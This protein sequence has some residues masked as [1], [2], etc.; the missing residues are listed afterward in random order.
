MVLVF[1]LGAMGVS[2]A[3]G[4]A[5]ATDKEAKYLQEQFL[6]DDFLAVEL[7]DSLWFHMI[8][9]SEGKLPEEYSGL[10]INEN[11]EL[12][13]G[14]TE[15]VAISRFRK[16]LTPELIEEKTAQIL[17]IQGY[18]RMGAVGKAYDSKTS[19][20]YVRQE[21]SYNTIQ[22]LFLLLESQME[23]I[24]ISEI[25]TDEINN[26]VVVKT[27]DAEG[28]EHILKV[29]PSD[30]CGAVDI[31]IEKS[32]FEDVSEVRGGSTI[33]KNIS[34]NSYSIGTAGCNVY[35]Y[36][37]GNNGI[38]TAAHVMSDATN[39]V[40]LMDVNG[41]FPPV[42]PYTQFNITPNLISSSTK[43]L[44]AAFLPFNSSFS[45]SYV[46]TDGDS[47][48]DAGTYNSFYTGMSV[49][50]SGHT[51][52][53]TVGTI[54]SISHSTVHSGKKA[55]Q[56]LVTTIV[57]NGDSGGPVY[58]QAANNDFRPLGIVTTKNQGAS[59]QGTELGATKIKPILFNFDLRLRTASG[60]SSVTIGDLNGDGVVD[61]T[62]SRMLLQF[63]VG[64]ISLTSAQKYR[65]D[66][67]Q[68]NV[69]DTTD[70][71]LV[72]LKEVG[73]TPW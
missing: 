41:A 52:G 18:D 14:V 1:L 5:R 29:V 67:D 17:K 39:A 34:G 69:I 6:K 46:L 61:S 56:F 2:G 43:G 11:R 38:I 31:R 23:N 28:R 13:V 36:K 59:A 16:V 12:V 54:S 25:C 47:I 60:I 20:R 30:I 63:S 44:D 51:T 71:R 53:R 58:Y 66:V 57:N 35:N 10:Y 3:V 40:A 33:F 65:A 37:I 8:E 9:Q 55:C 49:I 64:S 22:G 42:A 4:E 45:P 68:D 32:V 19:V 70:S 27:D 48:L 50:K 73:N 7:A 21:Y 26:R 62:D 15:E 72:S 24:G